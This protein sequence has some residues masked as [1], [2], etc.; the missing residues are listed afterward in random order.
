M[1][2]SSRRS[3]SQEE[4][5]PVGDGESRK[6]DILE[7]EDFQSTPRIVVN[8]ISNKNWWWTEKLKFP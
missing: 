7:M 6:I 1:T 8:N 4:E 3:L 5:E 2:L